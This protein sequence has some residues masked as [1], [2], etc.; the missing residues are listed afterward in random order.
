MLIKR[1]VIERLKKLKRVEMLHLLRKDD[2]TA[3][4]YCEEED[5]IILF[6][7][8]LTFDTMAHWRHWG[9]GLDVSFEDFVL[10]FIGIRTPLHELLHYC[11]IESSK[12]AEYVALWLTWGNKELAQ[13]V[14]NLA[15][16]H[17]K[18]NKVGEIVA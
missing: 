8:V 5:E 15:Y 6:V 10:R 17:G 16:V 13:A 18:I 12:Q 7:D 2:E 9:K 3:A 4:Y 14:A 1:K 11:D